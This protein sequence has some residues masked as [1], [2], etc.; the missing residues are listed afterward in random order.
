MTW[1]KAEGVFSAPGTG[2]LGRAEGNLDV[3]RFRDVLY[4]QTRSKSFN[5][6]V[7][8]LLEMPENVPI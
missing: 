5:K 2:R 8:H 6:T 1:H 7:K 3:R 4:L